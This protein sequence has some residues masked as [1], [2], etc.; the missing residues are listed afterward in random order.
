MAAP[1]PA[2]GSQLTVGARAV[3][4]NQ[5]AEPFLAKIPPS[6]KADVT[7]MY[8][9]QVAWPLVGIHMALLPTGHVVSYGTPVGEARQGGFAYD[10]WDP[11]R[12]TGADTH[13]QSASMHQ[14]DSFCNALAQLPDGRLLMVGGNA[15]TAT[16]LYDPATGRQAMGAQLARQRWYTSVL[17]LPD[18][19]ILV[20]GGGN[21]YNTDAYLHPDDDSGVATTPEIGSGTGAWTSL[22]GATSTVAFGARDNRWWYP[23]AYIAPDGKVFG[24]SYD[25]LWKLDPSGAG[26]VTALGTLPTPIGVSGSSVMYAPGKLLFAGGGQH[27][28]G[29]DEVATNRA[30]LV[31]I[32]G[33]NPTVTGA[34]S[35]RLARNW[36]NLTVLPNGEV[37]ANGGTRV[38]VQ[39]GAANSAYQTEIWNPGTGKWRD[40]A[41]AQRI[42]SYHST[43]LLLPG[44][45]VLTAAGGVPG[46]EDNFNAEI[47]YPPYLFTK[48]P[49]GRVRWADRPQITSIAG[50]LTYGGSVTLGLADDRKLTSVSLIR[51]A[52]VTHSYNTDERRV[53]LTFRQSGRTVTATMP[54]NANLLPPGT[55]LLSGVGADGVPTPAQTV[56]VH[57]SGPGTVTLYDRDHTAADRTG[58]SLKVQFP[59]TDGVVKAGAEIR[60]QATDASKATDAELLIDGK[61]VDTKKIAQDRAALRWDPAARD[62]K[63]TMTVRVYD[64]LGNVTTKTQSVLVDNAKPVLTVTPGT[65]ARGTTITAGATAVRD[66]SGLTQ[67]RVH[68][69]SEPA[70]TATAAPWTVRLTNNNRRDGK[71]TITF[72]ARDKA[73]N[74]TVLQRPLYLDNQKPTVSFKSAP[75]NNTKLHGPVTI[76]ANAA[77]NL[78]VQQVELLVDGKVAGTDTTAEYRFT[79]TPSRY[80]TTFTVQLRAYDRAGNVAYGEKRT[81]RR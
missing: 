15:L 79:L 47:Y 57:R 38:G 68:I 49:G 39:G 35:M 8:S 32:N 36:L 6:A 78:G 56:T 30:T 74:V 19:R 59:V 27:K 80:G 43:A 11:A 77:D 17:R 23:R 61:L 26:K 67:L 55:Y 48:G 50:S 25:R 1:A 20:L 70:V 37:L 60:V 54:A 64:S 28:N 51:A 12:G 66:A 2:A 34:A 5:P 76:T 58:P 73:G 45:S 9:P 69:D 3:A 24:A 14:N 52:S 72:E 33:A 13:R 62:G 16:M 42:R 81:Y 63:A 53:P 29:T 40:G 7:G 21:S 31:D 10:D 41:A 75:K 65:Y 22:T 4:L 44:G 18:D 71:H 46:P